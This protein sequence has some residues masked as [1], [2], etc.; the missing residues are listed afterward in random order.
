MS[1]CICVRMRVHACTYVRVQTLF[2]L[3][4]TPNVIMNRL[5]VS[6]FY[7]RPLFL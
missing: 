3:A 4:G 7:W 1:V 6:Q 5:A 2:F